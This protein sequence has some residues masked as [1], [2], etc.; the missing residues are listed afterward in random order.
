MLDEALDLRDRVGDS[1]ALAMALEEQDRRQ[2]TARYEGSLAL[3]LRGAWPYIDSAQ[4][5]EG[6]HLDAIA[7][8]LEAVTRGELRRLVIN[9]PP[10]S[11]KS[12]LVSAAWPAW[13]WAQPEPSPTSG[14]GVQFLYAS[15]SY[16]LSV[17]DSLKTRRI[18]ESPWYQQ[19]WRRRF[20]LAGDQNAKQKFENDKNGYRLATS[21][22]GGL[23]GDGGQ[24]IVVDD[25]VDA[26]EACS[27]AIIESTLN[28]WDEAMS[29][30]L[31]DPKTG[32]YV[33]IMQRLHERDLT[34]HVL[35]K[36]VGDWCHLMLPMRYEHDRRCVTQLGWSDPR[37]RDGEL[38]CP[39]RFGE[40]EVAELER[41]LG[42]YGAAGQLQ[43]RPEPR[44]GG[45]IK[46]AY[47]K[48][49][50]PDDGRFPSVDYVVASLDPAF[51]KNE[52][53]DPSGFTVWG[54]FMDP[55]GQRSA[56]LLHA[57]R[58]WLE[59]HGPEQPRLQGETDADY[60]ARTKND[61]GLCEWLADGC[62]HFK[63]DCLLIEAKASGHTVAQEMHRLHGDE[64]WS[65][66]LIDPKSLDKIARIQRVQPIFSAGQVWAPDRKYATMV[67][68]E[69]ASFPN[70][71]HDDLADSVS[72]ALWHMRQGGFLSRRREDEIADT[73]RARHYREEEA[74]YPA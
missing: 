71:E 55:T 69:L 61:W 5:T 40:S 15:H 17:R 47:W 56:I 58:K 66:H 68:D 27:E 35:S 21:V 3:F 41:T 22:G 53:N 34:G 60:R 46:R 63:V 49:W 9:V 1:V 51:T 33:I 67:I 13:T 26:S 44:G 59:I 24:I 54:A 29:T 73:E 11:S 8:H 48:N 16:R 65:V 74:L 64:P 62:R 14:P 70:G 39:S 2:D 18:I 20:K 6:W 36:N 37:T 57:W 4:Y 45:L 32:A 12:S 10:R 38:L 30:R 42:P 50:E 28:W 31:N 7:E 25:P 43:Q 19:R 52:I 72:Q 23:T